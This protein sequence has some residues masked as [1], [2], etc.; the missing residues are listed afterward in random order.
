[1]KF[2]YGLISYCF[3]I[4]GY[5]GGTLV[6]CPAS[7]MKQWEAE[8][9]NRCKRGLLSVLVFH[10]NNRALD[11]RKLSKYNIV[12]TTYQIIVREADAESGMY[13]VSS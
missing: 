6:V 10:G 2:I 11:D 5:Y 8:V 3:I 7:L 13:R 9:K 12:V 1:M 4:L